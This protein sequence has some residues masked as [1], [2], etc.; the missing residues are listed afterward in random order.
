M[1]LT[2]PTTDTLRKLQGEIAQLRGDISR[3]EDDGG[4]PSGDPARVTVKLFESTHLGYGDAQKVRDFRYNRIHGSIDARWPNQ[5]RAGLQVQ[6][7][8]AN[9]DRVPV[10]AR[11]WTTVDGGNHPMIY[12]IVQDEIWGLRFGTLTQNGV[13]DAL[14][15]NATSAMLHDNGSAIPLIYVG[16]GGASE[17]NIRSTTRFTPGGTNATVTAAG[18]TL[19]ADLL[20]SLNGRAYRT[21]TPSSGEANC[22]ISTLPIGANPITAANWGAAQLVGLASTDITAI[23]AVRHLP[24]A[25][26]PEGI[27]MYDEDLDRWVN[28]TPGWVTFIHLDTGKGSFSLGEQAV[29]PLGDGGAVIFDGFNIREFDPAG[30]EA[31][32]NVHTTT[33]HIDVLGN[34]KYWLMGVT[35]PKTKETAAAAALKIF[36]FD[37]NGSTYTDSSS[38]LAG[39][40]L[41]TSVTWTINETTDY[42]YVGFARPFVAVAID[43]STVQTNAS[44]ITAEVS[45]GASGWNSIAV[46][47]FTR[48]GGASFGQSGRIVMR[49]DPVATQNWAAD[50]V[51]SVDDLYWVR[52]SWG[53]GFSGG[54]VATNLRIQPWHPSVDDTNF[55]LD[56]LDKS[57][58]FPHV[59]AGTKDRQTNVWHDLVTL[60]EPDEIGAILYG[61]VGGTKINRYRSLIIVG[62]FRV[63]RVDISATDHPGAEEVPI[64]NDK[65][66]VEA[67]SI[68]PASNHLCRLTHV[69]INGQEA[70]PNLLGRF[71]YTWDYGNPWSHAGTV[72]RFPADFEINQ[73]QRGYRLRWA[74]GWSQS[75]TT[76]RLTQPALTEIEAD[77]EV[78]P[79]K[80][81]SVQERSLAAEPRF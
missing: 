13:A 45:D 50:T 18:G 64:I 4:G 55:P 71:Y 17:Q 30:F 7:L 21:L 11:E 2:G 81:D 40:N 34:M 39:G 16:F 54:V 37:N 63:W 35:S 42:I 15:A 48:L 59:I 22:Q 32:P 8:D 41:T 14:G 74:W 5:I 53:A 79:D 33:S 25:V 52:F 24:V 28:R 36:H 56:G 73:P 80:L 69:R 67:P 9:W 66:L 23:T 26:K 57:G 6:P 43:F 49:A 3:K 65:A 10:F 47:D 58:V 44:T 20:Y 12:I 29:I 38:N 76:P 1:S 78:L 68:V 62:R 61:N 19:R 31:A 60:D 46:R 75:A 51:N 27:F 70:D 72:Q 77:F